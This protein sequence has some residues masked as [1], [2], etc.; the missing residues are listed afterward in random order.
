M[1]T[2][3][4]YLK[5]DVYELLRRTLHSGE[6]ETACYM[7]AELVCAPG[8][9]EIPA[10][11]AFLID[12]VCQCD[13][14]NRVN[15]T[16]LLCEI[17]RLMGA[18][19]TLV[20]DGV[21]T[22]KKKNKSKTTSKRSKQEDDDDNNGGGK[23]SESGHVIRKGVCRLVVLASACCNA[24][25]RKQVSCLS[26]EHRHAVL[27]ESV[28]KDPA[29]VETKSIEIKRELLLL[30]SH[31]SVD[32]KIRKAF[33]PTTIPR[34]YTKLLRFLYEL[35]AHF[36]TPACLESVA[37]VV[38]ATDVLETV[39]EPHRIDFPEISA[40]PPK[41]R[42]DIVWYLWRLCLLVTEGSRKRFS[43]G[44]LQAYQT[45]YKKGKRREVRMPLLLMSFEVALEGLGP[46]TGGE[47]DE[48]CH[49]DA[50]FLEKICTNTEKAEKAI[51]FVYEDIL[52]PVVSAFSPPPLQAND[53]VEQA[54]D[55]QQAREMKGRRQPLS[56][57]T[58]DDDRSAK[59]P[60]RKARPLTAATALTTISSDRDDYPDQRFD[61]APYTSMN[62]EL[63]EEIDGDDRFIEIPPD[64]GNRVDYDRDTIYIEE[65]KKQK[66]WTSRKATSTRT[67]KT[68]TRHSNNNDLKS[69]IIN[70]SDDDPHEQQ[71]LGG[72]G[73]KRDRS[74]DL[75]CMF[76][77]SPIDHAKRF[78]IMREI[79]RNR[80]DEERDAASL[81]KRV[82]YKNCGGSGGG[83]YLGSSSSTSVGSGRGIGFGS[84]VIKY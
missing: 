36:R 46:R 84:K 13:F 81:L 14:I 20:N 37:C 67:R 31:S 4:G 1:T 65:P 82:H 71:D 30:P 29:I 58:L 11:C 6:L 64:I 35:C 18:A 38:K 62:K 56:D 60:P 51:D 2:V 83:G 80:E 28:T 27:L 17:F 57:N 41:Q 68:R 42:E 5:K 53:K 9:N 72:E 66:E 25:R 70:M 63:Y 22:S 50:V 10:L 40:V 43:T 76:F 75:D 16:R 33:F 19:L 73:E 21:L 32:D 48:V 49:S 15:D 59:P 12:E 69:T 23:G 77:Y 47:S 61:F 54:V 79:E 74:A 24:V 52:K 78:E 3:S 26:S 44:A 34:E 45:G 8:G 55:A 7:S 39:N